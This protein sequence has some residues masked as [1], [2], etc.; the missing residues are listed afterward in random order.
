MKILAVKLSSLGDLF[1]ALPAVHNLKVGLNAEIDWVTQDE[2]VDVVRCFTDVNRIIPFDR[3]HFVRSFRPFR[4]E[5]RETDYDMAIDFQGLLK[6]AVVCKLAKA[7]KRIGPSF[8]R[9]GAHIFYSD[10]AGERN[11][12][13]HAVEE[14]LDVVRHLGLEVIPPAFPV[15]FPDVASFDSRVA[16]L[17]RPR[18]AIVPASR[19][20]TKNWPIDRFRETALRLQRE[21][22]ASVV[23]L[24]G[25][26]D[27]M[28]CADAALGM[29]GNVLNL[30]GRTTFPSMGGILTAMDALLC[31]DSGPMH[32]A[33]AV[34]TPVVAVFGPTDPLRT[35]PYGAGHRVVQAE[36][37]CRPCFSRTCKE[38]GIPCMTT[39]T[40]DRVVQEISTL[41]SAKPS[42]PA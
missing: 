36:L 26:T 28:V 27:R 4:H 24:G 13:R 22:G 21:L 12:E 33:A 19:W 9:E 42:A 5:L 38:R 6:S 14:N 2:Y 34:G 20:S 30:A 10:V 11:K 18:V 32:V 39:I 40:V 23:F 25:P 8:Q 1:H 37:D 41:L 31:N 16:D 3:N 35:G 15:R 29:R 7:E 17:P